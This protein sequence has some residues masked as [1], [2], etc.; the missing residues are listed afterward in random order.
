MRIKVVYSL[1]GADD[2]AFTGGVHDITVLGDGT[3]EAPFVSPAVVGGAEA[4]GVVEVVEASETERAALDSAVQSQE[5]GEAAYATA[6][7]EGGGWHEGNLEQFLITAYHELSDPDNE[8]SEERRAWLE[9]GIA[10][11]E[12]RRAELGA[13]Q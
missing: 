1:W 2:V 13:K 6:Q 11:A 9:Q 12:V 5:D 10:D 4:A 3:D 8:V 7:E